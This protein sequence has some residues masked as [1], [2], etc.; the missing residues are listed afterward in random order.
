M[1][2]LCIIQE[3][4]ADGIVEYAEILVFVQSALK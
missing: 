2:K 1:L 4:V 3:Q